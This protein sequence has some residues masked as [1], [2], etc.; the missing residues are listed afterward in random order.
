MPTTV[1]HTMLV[2]LPAAVAF[3]KDL[4]AWTHGVAS[5]ASASLFLQACGVELFSSG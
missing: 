2:S 5:E 4:A 3:V 1:K